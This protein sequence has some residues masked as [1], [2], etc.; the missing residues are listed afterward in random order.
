MFNDKI[1]IFRLLKDNTYLKFQLENLYFEHNKGVNISKNGIN[2]ISTGF[3]MIPT[4]DK[5]NLKEKDYVVEGLID[6]VLDMN[7][8]IKSLQE[9]YQVYTVLVVDDCRKGSLPHWEV[10]LG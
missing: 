10:T 4:K 7:T 9:K 3:I 5:I 8:R 6:D 1:T 2:N